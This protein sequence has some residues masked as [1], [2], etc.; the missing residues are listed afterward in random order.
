MCKVS[1]ETI[2]RAN[3]KMRKYKIGQN[4]KKV[5]SK[6]FTVNTQVH[7]KTYSQTFTENSINAI[8]K[9]VLSNRQYGKTL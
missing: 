5:S 4:L 8:F 3:E 6:G 7:G 9:R 2:L 1:E